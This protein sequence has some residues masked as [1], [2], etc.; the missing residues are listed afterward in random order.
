MK[1]LRNTTPEEVQQMM[2]IAGRPEHVTNLMRDF[3]KGIDVNNAAEIQNALLALHR[4]KLEMN[5]MLR[6]L[7]KKTGQRYR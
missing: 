5:F 2:S 7:E 1:S 3:D 4:L 6:R